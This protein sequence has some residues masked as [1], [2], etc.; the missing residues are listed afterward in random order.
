MSKIKFETYRGYNINFDFLRKQRVYLKLGNG[1]SEE[2]SLLNL[3]TIMQKREYTL[4]D[5][6]FTINSC[7]PAPSWIMTILDHTWCPEHRV[8]D[9]FQRYYF[10]DYFTNSEL[11]CEYFCFFSVDGKFR[12]GISESPLKFASSLIEDDDALP[13]ELFVTEHENIFLKLSSGANRAKAEAIYWNNEFLKTKAGS[14]ANIFRK[15]EDAENTD[16]TQ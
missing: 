7:D 12:K 1:S 5:L 14:I 11:L 9:F 16:A 3:P 10:Y 15:L 4:E 6:D 8:F 2:V 13:K